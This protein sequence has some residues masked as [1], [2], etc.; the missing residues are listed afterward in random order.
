M[1]SYDAQNQGQPVPTTLTS[2]YTNRLATQQTATPSAPNLFGG[3]AQ[4]TSSYGADLQSAATGYTQGANANPSAT[5]YGE[6]GAQ[7]ALTQDSET[8]DLFK[9][10]YE[11]N[12]VE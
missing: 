12:G 4:P 2:S 3:Q 9:F 8:H 10:A 11:Q 7:N 1:P 5:V 6:Q